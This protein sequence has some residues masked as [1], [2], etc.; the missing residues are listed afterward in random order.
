MAE[1]TMRLGQDLQEW[2]AILC[3]LEKPHS[4]SDVNHE[5]STFKQILNNVNIDKIIDCYKNIRIIS[6]K[7]TSFANEWLSY[8]ALF[9]MNMSTLYSKISFYCAFIDS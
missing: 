4:E 7:P 2:L 5:S 1:C 6:D 8:Q 3:D 9:S